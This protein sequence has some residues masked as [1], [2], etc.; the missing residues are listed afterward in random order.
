MNVRSF[1]FPLREICGSPAPKVD[2]SIWLAVRPAGNVLLGYEPSF[3]ASA[4][5]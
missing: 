5:D 2:R 4:D 3:S 1:V